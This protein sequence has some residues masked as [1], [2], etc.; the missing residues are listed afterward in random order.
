MIVDIAALFLMARNSVNPQG[1]P[2][3]FLSL[4]GINR[5]KFVNNFLL[6]E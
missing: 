3:P 6:K 5:I 4:P 2:N 1:K